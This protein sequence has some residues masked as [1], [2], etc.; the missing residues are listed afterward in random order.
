MN[1]CANSIQYLDILDQ[2]CLLDLRQFIV[3]YLSTCSTPYPLETPCDAL[4]I[5]SIRAGDFGDENDLPCFP[6]LDHLIGSLFCKSISSSIQK[7]HTVVEIW[8]KVGTRSAVV[9]NL[10]ITPE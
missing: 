7:F 2:R 10:I 9:Y 5:N 4:T 8:A 1:P 6:P 3:Y